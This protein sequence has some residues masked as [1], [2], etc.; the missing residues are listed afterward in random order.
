MKKIRKTD[1]KAAD[2]TVYY[3][4][5]NPSEFVVYDLKYG[6]S[7]IGRN[8]TKCQVALRFTSD[9]DDVH[10]KI[11]IEDSEYTIED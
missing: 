11:T 5:K 9:L 4:E 1:A 6:D 3:D 8:S 2:L 10:T 7:I